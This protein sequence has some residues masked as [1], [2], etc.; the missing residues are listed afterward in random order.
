[1]NLPHDH[2]P[3][4]PHLQ[5]Y[6]QEAQ[7]FDTATDLMKLMADGKRLQLFW[8][9]CH[10]EECVVNLSA[11]LGLSSPSVSHHLRL[12]REAGLVERRRKGRETYYFAAHT[13]RAQILHDATEALLEMACPAGEFCDC[14]EHEGQLSQIRQVHDYLVEN[15]SR[16]ITTEALSERFHMSP[17]MLKSAF[18]RTYG[19]PLAQYMRHYRIQ[20]GMHLLGHGQPVAQVARACGYESSSKFSEAFRAETGML[21]KDWRKKEENPADK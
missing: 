13:T 16:R 11:M 10:C 18:R 9:L 2:G 19:K 20:Q 6:L 7:A 15:F 4:D 21:P 17:T 1:M 14:P 8:L 3:V 12:L 5:G